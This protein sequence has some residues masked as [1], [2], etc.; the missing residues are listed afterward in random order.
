[1]SNKM[2]VFLGIDTSN[3]T[4]S[5][6]LCDF[7][8]SIV[9]QQK[10][11]L[12]V[13]C[14]QKGLRQSDAVFQH[15]VNLPRVMEQLFGDSEGYHI[16]AI[17]YSRTPRDTEGSYMPCFLAGE[18][19]A[20]SCSA[21]LSIPAFSFSHQSGHIMAAMYSANMTLDQNPFLAFH[22]S[23]GTTDLLYV[24]YKDGQFISKKIG[25]SLDLHAGQIIDRVG[26]ML[27]LSFPAGPALE[28]LA[29]ACNT[30]APKP[31]TCVKGSFCNLS[32]L[33]NLTQGMFNAGDT[34]EIIAAFVFV[35]LQKT[36]SEML[37]HA[38]KQYRKMPV[39]FAGG[40]TGNRL[41]RPALS[42]CCSDCAFF[43]D[44]VFA[45]D[46]AAGIALLAKL[47]YG[48]AT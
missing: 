10:I 29:A 30:P 2:E 41:M 1:M 16:M 21:A 27:G 34:P 23:G 31:K 6:A 45:S 46:N 17:G 22:I 12:A 14:G 4:T 36:F 9:T 33:E 20:R 38:F 42:A 37:Q 8:G 11:P 44:P 25:G 7:E 28:A 26:V 19:A 47:K 18:A 3:Y 35:F 24:E 39:L 40:V 5:A 43:A 13:A 32:G 48:A 15:T